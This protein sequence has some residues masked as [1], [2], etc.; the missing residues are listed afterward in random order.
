MLLCLALPAQADELRPLC[1]DRPGKG[2]SPCTVDA[3]H[4]QVE[5]GL[6]DAAFQHRAGVTTDTFSAGAATFKYG[7]S[8]TVDLEAGFTFYQSLRTHDAISDT[9]L[10]GVGDLT[11]RTKWN[12][13]GDAGPWTAVIEPFVK[14]GTATRGLGN[15]ALEGGLVLPLSYDLGDGWSL[16]STPE[17]DILLNDAGHGRHAALVDVVGIGKALGP[18]TLGGEVWTAQGFDPDGASSQYSFDLDAA[19]LLNASWQLDGGVNLGLNRNA[20]GAELYAGIS[21]RL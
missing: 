18:V 17:L 13:L 21:T 6:A 16:A 1:P 12:W 4:A 8:D 10:D 3:G 15:G 2:T 14:L 5:A 19:W 11:L 7:V 9:T 20:P